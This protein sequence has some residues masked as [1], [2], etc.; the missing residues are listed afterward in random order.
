[1]NARHPPRRQRS[2]RRRKLSE[3]PYAPFLPG[4]PPPRRYRLTIEATPSPLP[5]IIRLRHVL[6][7]LLRSYAF[8]VVHVR[9]I[10]EDP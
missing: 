5:P 10:R 7:R 9:E 8:R 1:M 2:G 3:R 6:K 4:R